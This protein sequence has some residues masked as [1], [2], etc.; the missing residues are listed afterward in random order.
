MVFQDILLD[1][2]KLTELK[3]EGVLQSFVEHSKVYFDKGTHAYPGVDYT[4][5]EIANASIE[6]L[7]EYWYTQAL[8]FASDTKPENAPGRRLYCMLVDGYPINL[9]F[10]EVKGTTIHMCNTLHRPDTQGT[11]NYMFKYEYHNARGA[12]YLADDVTL[13]R[14]YVDIGGPM[15]QSIEAIAAYFSSIEECNVRDFST[16]RYVGQETQ[17]YS[18]GG[19]AWPGIKSEYSTTFDVFEMEIKS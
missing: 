14:T 7:T 18:T 16:C 5:E 2:A 3:A 4:E 17:H 13:E 9:S 1:S 12:S 15:K 19:Q 6:T 11:K 8:S 10:C